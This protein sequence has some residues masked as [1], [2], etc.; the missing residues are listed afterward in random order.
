MS[1]LI[2]LFTLFQLPVPVST[3]NAGVS[4]F[5]VTFVSTPV[6]TT[7][8]QT[9]PVA[10]SNSNWKTEKLLPFLE[11]NNCVQGVK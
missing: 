3:L 1:K 11:V 4:A 9:V 6:L 8:P 5:P 2:F 7:S 10:T